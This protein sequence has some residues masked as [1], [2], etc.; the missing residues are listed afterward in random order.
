MSQ[1]SYH[2]NNL[3]IMAMPSTRAWQQIFQ[4]AAMTRRTSLQ[5]MDM[6]TSL[7]H[8]SY[9]KMGWGSETFTSLSNLTAP[10]TCRRCACLSSPPAASVSVRCF[11][12]HHLTVQARQVSPCPGPTMMMTAIPVTGM[13][14]HFAVGR[15][16]LENARPS[17]SVM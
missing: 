3:A 4:R 11:G 5:Y 1:C 14:S 10:C 2:E 17:E 15:A 7:C 16:E 6:K 9:S 12:A 13:C 8:S